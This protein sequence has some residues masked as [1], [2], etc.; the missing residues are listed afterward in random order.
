MWSSRWVN[1]SLRR[2]LKQGAADARQA[3]RAVRL[4]INELRNTFRRSKM[5]VRVQV[6]IELN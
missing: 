5:V 2:L 4:H 3:D 1:A 6:Y